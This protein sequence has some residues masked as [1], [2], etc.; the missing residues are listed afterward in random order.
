ML[1]SAS[2]HDGNNMLAYSTPVGINFVRI[3]PA[4]NA[5]SIAFK[6]C[7]WVGGGKNKG[8]DL[9]WELWT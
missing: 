8:I 2:L 9:S 3:D 5:T 1:H 4:W 7:V 6:M